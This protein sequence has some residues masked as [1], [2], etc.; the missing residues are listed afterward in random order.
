M[1]IA[2]SSPRCQEKSY[3][4]FA[5]SD[6]GKKTRIAELAQAKDKKRSRE[7]PVKAFGGGDQK[8]VRGERSFAIAFVLGAP[9]LKKK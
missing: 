3:D 2:A 6:H 7:P 1:S 5:R 8:K 9:I 4:I